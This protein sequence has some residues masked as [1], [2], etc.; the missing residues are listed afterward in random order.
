MFDSLLQ[1]KLYQPSTRPDWVQRPRLLARL[2]LSPQT[3]LVLISA[4]AGYGKTT[5]V[6][7]WLR[8]LDGVPVCWLSLDED[9][10]DPQQFFR[11]V[12]AA[13]RPLPHSQT[14]LD[15]LL[16]TNQTIPAKTL[17]KALVNDLVPVP[18]PFLLILDDYHAIDSAEVDGALASLLDLM[19]PQMTLSLTSRSDPGFPISRLRARGQLIELRAD[20]LRFTE[21]EAAEFLQ[22]TMGLTLLP[23]QI[24][25]LENRTE[26]WIA[27]LQMAALSMQNRG[28]DLDGFVQS[29]TGSHRF[30]MD[31]LTDE[32]LAQVSPDVQAFLLQTAVLH[33]LHANLCDAVLAN[34]QSPISNLP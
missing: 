24:A 9:D 29:F 11:Y 3:K 8:Q 18:E 2:A 7:H 20:D 28:G 26:G 33:R 1:T 22:Q 19:P 15:Q 4:P 12:A 32:V 6:T 31:Y 5:L 25:A 14:S 30:I 10:S 13:I 27:G 21:A 23:G 17:L 16:Q 34:H